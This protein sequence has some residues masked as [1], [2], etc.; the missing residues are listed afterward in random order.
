MKAI[1]NKQLLKVS[2]LKERT[3]WLFGDQVL[4]LYCNHYSYGNCDFDF[5]LGGI[6][7]KKVTKWIPKCNLF[8]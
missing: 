2:K 4:V 5:P 6:Y 8:E 1:I 7:L 3:H